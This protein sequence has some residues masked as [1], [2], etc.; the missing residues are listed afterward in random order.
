MGMQLAVFGAA[1]TVEAIG[2]DVAAA[3]A[4]GFPSYWTPQ[5][6]GPDALTAL[7]LAG[8]HT[9]HIRLGT[10]VVPVQPRH[11]MA[12]AQQALT[13]NQV[14]AGRLDL[15]IGLSHQPVVEG[16]WGIPFDRP[17]R[18]M[19]D[20]LAVLMPLLHGEKVSH[21]G[22]KV[23]GRGEIQVRAEAPP[24]YVAALGEQMLKLAGRRTDGTVTWMTGSATIADLTVPTI[25]AAAAAAGRAAP[26]VIA[27]VPVCLAADEAEIGALRQRAAE[28]YVVYGQLPSYRAMLDHEGL[29]GPAD[30]ALIGSIDLIAEGLQRFFDAGATLVVVNTFGSVDQQVATREAVAA[31]L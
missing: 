5:I 9:P 2:E 3:A 30:L 20:Y 1:N 12:L 8:A 27:A 4:L 22:E 23:T 24:V 11:P 21:G 31:L 10:A 29:A 17:V 28:E 14:A 18:Y 13:V 7:A 26:R 6:F 19:S 25:T 15:G 16:M